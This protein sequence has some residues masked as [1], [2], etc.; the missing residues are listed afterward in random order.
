MDEAAVHGMFESGDPVST[1]LGDK[2]LW[3]GLAGNPTLG[4]A[5][6]GALTRVDQWLA[7]RGCSV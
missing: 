5:V 4:S 1:F 2:L 6:R 7:S 3:G